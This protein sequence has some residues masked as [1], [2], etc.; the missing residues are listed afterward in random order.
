MD[1]QTSLHLTALKVHT[2]TAHLL[3]RP[4]QNVQDEDDIAPFHLA[5]QEGH[6]DIA[7]DKT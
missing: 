2:D 5:A 6:I 1:G 7:D 3:M 4:R